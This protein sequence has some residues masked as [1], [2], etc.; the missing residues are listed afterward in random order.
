MAVADK[1]KLWVL[2]IKADNTETFSTIAG[3]VDVEFSGST[4]LDDVTTKEDNEW[5]A[6]LAGR[7]TAQISANGICRDVSG[8]DQLATLWA[9]SAEKVFQVVGE[10]GTGFQGPFLITTFSSTGGTDGAQKFA[11]TLQSMGIVSTIE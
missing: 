10:S 4:G 3:L 11:V 5:S 9:T 1:A 6:N 8:Y 7:K 2:K